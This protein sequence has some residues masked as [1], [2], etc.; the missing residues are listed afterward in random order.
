[1]Q[2]QQISLPEMSHRVRSKRRLKNFLTSRCSFVRPL[3]TGSAHKY[4]F[5]LILL[6][7]QD[8]FHTHE[9]LRSFPGGFTLYQF[10]FH[11]PDLFSIDSQDHREDKAEEKVS[12]ESE[13]CKIHQRSREDE[14][15]V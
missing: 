5:E 11:D 14:F 4:S 3:L 1:M 8:N 10:A 12:N 2:L 9:E 13:I 6:L 15:I 7:F